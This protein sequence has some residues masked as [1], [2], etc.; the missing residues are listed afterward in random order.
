MNTT[1]SSET[2]SVL[3]APEPPTAPGRVEMRMTVSDAGLQRSQL[4]LALLMILAPAIGVGAAIW[5]AVTTGL[6]VAEVAIF[7][8]MYASTTIGVTVGFHRHFAHRAFKARP[9]VRL[10]LGILGSMAIQGPLIFWTATHRRHHSFSDR[11]GD[12][13]SPNLFGTGWRSWLEGEWHAHIRWL[14]AGKLT[15]SV[16]FA[17]DLRRDKIAVWVNQTYAL[18]AIVG[19]VLPTLLGA[20][21]LGGWTGALKGFLW[22]G[23][24][25]LF[26]VHHAFWSIGSI[27]HTFGTRPYAT[28]DF[29]GNSFWLALPNFGEGW[30]NNHHAFPG[31][32]FFGLRWWQVDVGGYVIRALHRLG[33]I[34]DVKH[35]TMEQMEDMK[36]TLARRGNL[37]SP[38][39]SN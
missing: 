26:V 29:S 2:L 21:W 14:Y 27:A 38:S 9:V 12:P 20:F 31:S 4:R 3:L 15:N 39:S 37:T 34:T 28:D 5:L 7:L 30:H 6:H 32:A 23:M 22:G 8:L 35:P 10:G 18:W 16:R 24:V 11:E 19:L 25:R 1:P 33:G 17:N 36:V 13:H